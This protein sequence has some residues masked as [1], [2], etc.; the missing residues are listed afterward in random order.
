M[1]PAID[2]VGKDFGRW[3]V[4]EVRRTQNGLRAWLCRCACG[5]ERVVLTASLVNGSSISCGCTRRDGVVVHGH[6][7]RGAQTATYETW[8]NMIRRC[9]DPSNLYYADYGGRGIAVCSRWRESFEAFLADVGERPAGMSIDRIDVDGDYEPDNV[10]WAT[11]VEQN[12]NRTSTRLVALS[13][14]LIRQF[15]LRGHSQRALARAFDVHCGTVSYVVRNKAWSNA[16]DSI[17][18]LGCQ[19]RH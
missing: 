15:Y 4:L 8:L 1:P 9:E 2:L 18:K 11:T 5:T 7:R 3:T 6:A 12:Q 17:E 19:A 14:I 10:R 16:L 13:A